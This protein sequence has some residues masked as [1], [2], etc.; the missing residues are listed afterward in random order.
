M[1]ELKLSVGEPFTSPAWGSNFVVFSCTDPIPENAAKEYLRKVCKYARGYGVYLV[2]E[3]FLLM[4]YQCMCLISPEGR[5]LGAQK[6]LYL[7]TVTRVGKHSAQMDVLRTE[8]GG[9]F[10]CV[11]VDI[12]HPEVVRIAESMGVHYVV[13]SQQIAPQEYGSSMVLTGP[14]NAAQTSN[15]YVIGVCDQFLCVCAPQ[16]IT[17]HEDGFIISPN[18]RTPMTAK[19]NA[20]LLARC[21]R[22]FRLSRKFYAIHRSDLLR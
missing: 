12:Y 10:L 22:P 7:N 5:V 18:L 13:C 17:K 6:G 8:F 3:R 2:P 9:I 4:G 19:L 16:E 15:T 14:W 11:D 1:T 21:K 20:D